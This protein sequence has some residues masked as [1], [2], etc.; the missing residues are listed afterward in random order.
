MENM[1][2]M[3]TPIVQYGFAGLCAILLAI[4]VWLI[5]QL[6]RVLSQ[7][8]RALRDVHEAIAATTNAIVTLS[9]RTGDEL[10][11]LRELE[12]QLLSRP[13]LSSREP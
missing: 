1:S 13:C 2:P 4:I 6:L 9:E 7:T 10:K 5:K 12:K 3:L 8:N 11:L